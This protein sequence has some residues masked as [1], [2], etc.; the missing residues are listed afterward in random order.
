MSITRDDNLPQGQRDTSKRP[1]EGGDFLAPLDM[2]SHGRLVFVDGVDALTLRSSAQ[3]DILLQARFVRHTPQIWHQSGIVTIQDRRPPL[4]DQLLDW[5]PSP[6]DVRLNGAIPWE[7]EFQGGVSRL[8]ADLADIPLRSLD[9]L[10]GASQIRLNLS[11]PR[12]TTFIHISGGISRGAMHVPSRTAVRMQIS[13]GASRL[14]FAGQQFGAIGGE[15]ALR[16]TAFDGS[17]SHYDI[18]ITGGVSHLK[19]ETNSEEVSI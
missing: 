5:R 16:T 13:G 3:E 15:I 2:S 18:C 8:N 19:I 7:L 17:A 12:Q 10:S 4:L 14:T 1:D 6:T 9:I 11:T